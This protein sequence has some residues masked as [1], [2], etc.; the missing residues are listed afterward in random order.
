MDI[1]ATIQAVI[2]NTS[3]VSHIRQISDPLF[4]VTGGRLEK[5]GELYYLVGGQKFIGRYNPMGPDMGPGFIQ[6]YTNQIR[7]FTIEDDR[8]HY[9][10][11]KSPPKRL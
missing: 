9:R 2:N 7:K 11:S 10:Y 3:L 1:P 5:I 8:K 4:Q 6:E